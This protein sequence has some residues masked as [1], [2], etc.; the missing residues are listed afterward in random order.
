MFQGTFGHF[1]AQK[2]KKLLAIFSMIVG[3]EVQLCCIK[4]LDQPKFA[5]QSPIYWIGP[6]RLGF[7]WIEAFG[8]TRFELCNFT[9]IIFFFFLEESLLLFSTKKS[10][11]RIFGYL[12][13]INRKL[14]KVRFH[15]FKVQLQ[16]TLEEFS[17]VHYVVIYK[18]MNVYYICNC[19]Y[20]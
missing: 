10:V 5:I 2:K 12:F 20:Q 9:P 7:T 18:T 19:K 17:L 1:F 13:S 15:Y 3:G 11:F 4:I 14:V 6:M 8:P 16:I